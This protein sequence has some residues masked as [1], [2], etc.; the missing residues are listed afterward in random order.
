MSG[1]RSLALAAILSAAIAAPAL[2]HR[3]NVFASVEEDMV[4]VEARFS[5]GRVPAMGEVTVED[6]NGAV[7]ATLPLGE[8]GIAQFSLAG[9]PFED[10]LSIT[11]TTGDDHEGYW[12][13]TPADIAAGGEGS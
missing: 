3:V 8:D 13:L 6:A 11:V 2:A 10:G 12:L 9:L 4:T 1:A 5:T 7:L